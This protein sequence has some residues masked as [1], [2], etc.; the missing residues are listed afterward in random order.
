[1]KDY[2]SVQE[3]EDNPAALAGA[4]IMEGK[5]HEK[6]GEALATDGV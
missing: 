4:V 5:T 2:K 3:I 1:M 6:E